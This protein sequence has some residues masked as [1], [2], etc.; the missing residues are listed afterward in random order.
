MNGE[1]IERACRLAELEELGVW[2][3]KEGLPFAASCD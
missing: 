1:R 2:V 3:Y